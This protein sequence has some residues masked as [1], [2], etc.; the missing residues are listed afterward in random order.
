TGW[1][2][3]AYGTGHR[4]KLAYT[5]TMITAALSG[6]LSEVNFKTHPIF[7]VAVPGAVPGVPAEILD[8]RNTWADK[9]AYDHTAASLAEKFVKNFEKYADYATAD[10]LAGAPRLAVEA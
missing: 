7:G 5:R 3:G 1:T 10:L 9:D 6:V 8:P 2:G 4:M